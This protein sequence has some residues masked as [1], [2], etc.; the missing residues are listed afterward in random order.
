MSGD[1]QRFLEAGMDAYLS[2]P[3]EPESLFATLDALLTHETA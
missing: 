3:I 1:D 2:K